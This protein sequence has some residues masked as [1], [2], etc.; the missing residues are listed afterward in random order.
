[1][2]YQRFRL[3]DQDRTKIVSGVSCAALL[4][5]NGYLLD[6]A[7]ST[8]K[9]LKYRNGAS[10][11]IV[12]HEGRGWWHANG[13]EKGDVF[14]LM[15]HLHPEMGWRDVC[16]ELGQLIGVEP[17]GAAYVRSRPATTDTRAP[18][19]RW[20]Q[21]KSLR[22][23]GRVWDYLVRERCLP[24]DVVR[25]AA[26]KGCIRDGY[27]AAWFAHTDA[28]GKVCGAELRGPETHM[29]LGGTIKSLFRFQPG[30]AAQVRRLVVCEAAIDALSF[31]ALDR[32]RTPDTMYCSTGGAMG[33][34]TK[35]AIRAHLADM[36]QIPD[37]VLIVAT[38]DDDAGDGFADTLYG[39]AED[40]GVEFARRL[41]PDRSKD[42]NSTL[43]NMAAAAA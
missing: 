5:K 16:L 40:A 30:S 35:A 39:L 33:P 11:V 26:M 42:F 18:A 2:K 21:K 9:C 31:A 6:K 34:E 10:N 22:R 38:D 37:A 27:H 8:R 15:R 24:E 12:N 25:R 4:E 23:G 20:A 41:P 17:E 14:A 13:D 29:C 28:D 19:E 3:S 36:R 32:V 1:M 7:K 43:K